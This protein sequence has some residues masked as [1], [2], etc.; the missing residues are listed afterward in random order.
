MK[1]KMDARH[2]A[3]NL[4]RSTNTNRQMMNWPV[5][6]V[7]E[8]L[9]GLRE[10][11]SFNS[12]TKLRRSNPSTRAIQHGTLIANTHRMPSAVKLESSSLSSRPEC[13]SKC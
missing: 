12:D 2:A 9:L 6:Q 8:H 4:N 1:K 13:D 7:A 3:E 5:P 10:R 11:A